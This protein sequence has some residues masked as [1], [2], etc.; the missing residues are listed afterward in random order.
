MWEKRTLCMRIHC[1]I[2]CRW[3]QDLHSL[4]AGQPEE[5][6]ICSMS[7]GW[8][9]KQPARAQAWTSN[10]DCPISTRIPTNICKVFLS[11][12]NLPVASKAMINSTLLSFSWPIPFLILGPQ[13][14][15]SVL[16]NTSEVKPTKQ[17]I[18]TEGLKFSLL[19]AG[20]YPVVVHVCCVNQFMLCHHFVLFIRPLE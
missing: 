5:K 16:G 19:P 2:H 14:W 7:A 17:R 15:F 20:D 12:L 8:G 3:W 9:P 11:P 13:S 10:Y 1:R 4:L 6:A 18:K